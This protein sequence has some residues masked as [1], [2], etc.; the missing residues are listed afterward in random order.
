MII[1]S[2]T[3]A[4]FLHFFQMD[5]SPPKKSKHMIAFSRSNPR[6]TMTDYAPIPRNRKPM[7]NFNYHSFSLIIIDK[8]TAIRKQRKRKYNLKENKGKKRMKRLTSLVNKLGKTK[9]QFLALPISN[10]LQILNDIDPSIS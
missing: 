6:R 1:I 5:F 2:D 4:I 10:S 7:L 9:Y 8:K 3:N